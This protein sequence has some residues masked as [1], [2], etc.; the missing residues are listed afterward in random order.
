M[1]V[2]VTARGP[3][4]SSEVDPRFGRARYLIVVNTGTGEF[5]AHDNAQHAE[6]GRGAGTRAGRYVVELGADALVTGRV[7]P[8]ALATLRAGDVAIFTGAS[9]SVRDAVEQF[10]AGRL[11]PADE[12]LNGES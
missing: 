4:P 12:T 6:A 9:G 8:R 7:G 10:K 1:N 2:A 11:E 5:T 3:D